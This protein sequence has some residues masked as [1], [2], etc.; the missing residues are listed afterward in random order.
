MAGR[1]IAKAAQQKLKQFFRRVRRQ[2][3]IDNG[4]HPPVEFFLTV[5]MHMVMPRQPADVSVEAGTDVIQ[6]VHH[7]DQLLAERLFEKPREIKRE[8]V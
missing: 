1:Q 2:V 6:F 5:R 7:G 4:V 8:N 3:P